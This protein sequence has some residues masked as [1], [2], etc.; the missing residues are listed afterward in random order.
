A[1][2]DVTEDLMVYGDTN[3]VGDANIVGDETI[4]GTLFIEAPIDAEEASH[5]M[6]MRAYYWGAGG[7]AYL[8]EDS[9]IA[10]LT[11]F[12]DESAGGAVGPEEALMARYLVNNGTTV[13]HGDI[14]LT[15]GNTATIAGSGG[16]TLVLAFDRPIVPGQ[17][18]KL[19]LNH[20]GVLSYQLVLELMFLD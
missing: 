6:F 1:Y 15:D 8:Y 9:L 18:G 5:R 16:E 17:T 19:W 11:I 3:I 20:T 10:D 14:Y 12:A 7:F 4:Y 13:T 2:A